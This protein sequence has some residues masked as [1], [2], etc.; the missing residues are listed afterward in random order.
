MAQQPKD[1]RV[2]DNMDHFGTPDHGETV[3]NIVR[4]D[5]KELREVVKDYQSETKEEFRRVR[6]KIDDMHQQFY[7][8]SRASAVDMKAIEVKQTESAKYAGR[9]AGAVA[10]FF[11]ALVTTVAGVLAK[12]LLLSS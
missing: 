8:D 9:L 1:K 2:K 12:Y 4:G 11:T 3:L 7:S 5:I 6:D 10:G